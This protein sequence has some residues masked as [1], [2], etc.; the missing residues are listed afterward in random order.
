MPT[1]PPQKLSVRVVR[2]FDA[3]PERVY[4]AWLDPGTARRFLFATA[5]GEMVRAEVD[6]RVGGRYAF[7]DRRDGEDMEHA[8]EYLELERPRRIVFTFGV[9]GSEP[10]RVAV[11]IVPLESGCELT[12]VHEMRPEWADFAGR[13]EQG[14][15]GIL[16]GLAAALG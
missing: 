13:T 5:G 9:N 12:L 8:G 14:W 6:A 1:N 3:P 16:E 4:D 11:E 7:V 15:A 10:D 2:R